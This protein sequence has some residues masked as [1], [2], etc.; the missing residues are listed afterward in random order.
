MPSLTLNKQVLCRPQQKLDQAKSENKLAVKTTEKI[1]DLIRLEVILGDACDVSDDSVIF[2]RPSNQPY[3]TTVYQAPIDGV[4][5]QVQFIIVPI[6]E[7]IIE[8]RNA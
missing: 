7:I 3:L 2:V 6:S 4:G 5:Q 8:E 1:Q